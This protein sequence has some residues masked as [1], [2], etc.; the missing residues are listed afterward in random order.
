MRPQPTLKDGE[1]GRRGD[2]V[3][4]VVPDAVTDLANIMRNLLLV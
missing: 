2:G 1:A 3:W 4:Q